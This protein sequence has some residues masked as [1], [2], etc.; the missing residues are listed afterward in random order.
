[1]AGTRPEA[2]CDPDGGAEE[3]DPLDYADPSDFTDELAP[4]ETAVIPQNPHRDL[5]PP[6][7]LPDLPKAQP[8][9]DPSTVQTPGTSAS[10]N[11][12]TYITPNNPMT[13]IVYQPPRQSITAQPTLPAAVPVTAVPVK[14]L[15]PVALPPALLHL[16]AP[17]AINL[18]VYTDK[19]ESDMGRRSGRA[20]L[21]RGK[22]YVI[23]ARTLLVNPHQTCRD[24]TF[25]LT[26]K[27]GTSY[28]EYNGVLV[29]YSWKAPWT[30][31]TAKNMYC[32][33]VAMRADAVTALRQTDKITASCA[34]IKE[35]ELEF[36]ILPAR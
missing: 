29:G 26:S 9:T 11:P 34:G 35:G 14:V 21:A 16:P 8:Q 24:V 18:G 33:R 30:F 1:M 12:M 17:N 6:V 23:E 4:G 3:V 20:A 25:T 7:V 5:P 22:T 27:N 36:E 13:P 15:P 10:V 32:A 2:R 28:L 19:K 31:D